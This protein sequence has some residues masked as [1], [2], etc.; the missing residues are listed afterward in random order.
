MTDFW[1]QATCLFTLNR[2][3]GF[4]RRAKPAGIGSKSVA[5]DW[6]APSRIVVAA[7]T[8]RFLFLDDDPGVNCKNT[9]PSHGTRRIHANERRGMAGGRGQKPGAG[10]VRSL[11]IAARDW[12]TN[13]SEQPIHRSAQR[14]ATGK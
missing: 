12:R 8:R 13:K 5:S 7:V 2:D 3:N 1:N 9:T 11:P 10:A 14:P 6:L 4:G